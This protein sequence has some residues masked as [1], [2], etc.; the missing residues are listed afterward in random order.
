MTIGDAKVL[1]QVIKEE[2]T[3]V[4]KK[5]IRT[6]FEPVNQKLDDQGKK[7][8]ILWDQV[9]RVTID[10]EEVKE[11]LGSHTK[12]LKN[13]EVK[14]ERNSDDTVK[15]NKRLTKVEQNLGIAPPPELTL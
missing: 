2:V 15:L 14:F 6:A 1:R 11:T 5:E 10:I 9:E 3:L 13:I 7:L 4:V 12:I 8:G